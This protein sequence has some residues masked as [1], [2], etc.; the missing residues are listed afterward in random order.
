M[1]HQQQP[2]SVLI[3]Q[4]QVEHLCELKRQLIKNGVPE[5]EVGLVHSYGD[6][7]S[8]PPTTGNETKRILLATHQ[9]IRTRANII[10][11]TNSVLVIIKTTTSYHV[12]KG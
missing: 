11:I 2:Y 8:L 4:T 1:W 9:C 3:C 12:T 6:R 7:V 10:T 5:A